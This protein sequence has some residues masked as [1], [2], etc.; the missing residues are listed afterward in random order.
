MSRDQPK[1]KFFAGHTNAMWRQGLAELRGALYNE[2]NVAQP[3]QPGLYGTKMPGEVMNDRLADSRDPDEQPR[4][5]L[6]E[7]LRQAELNRDGAE[8]ELPGM[9]RE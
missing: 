9:D 6:D 8:P 1:P 5:V 7:R 2:S 4:S 3:S